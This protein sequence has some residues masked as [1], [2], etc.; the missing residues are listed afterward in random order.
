MFPDGLK[1]VLNGILTHRDAE[2]EDNNKNITQKRPEK[3]K[4]KIVES[5]TLATHNL[6]SNYLSYC[7][8]T[9][10]F[11]MSVKTKKTFFKPFLKF[12]V[13][14]LFR[15]TQPRN[16]VVKELKLRFQVLENL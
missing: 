6:N 2:D 4:L 16:F 15:K 10:G 7:C 9:V 12:V 1:D 3:K 11:F 14:E 13:S 5:C 8:C